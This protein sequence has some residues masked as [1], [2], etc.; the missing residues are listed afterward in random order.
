[1]SGLAVLAGGG[2]Y[3]VSKIP[4]VLKKNA[5]VVKRMEQ[6]RFEVVNTGEAVLWK[7]YALTILD[8]KGDE[9]AGFLEY[10]DKLHEIKNIEGALFDSEGKELKRL[11]NRQIMDITGNDDDNLIDDRRRKYHNFYFK[12]YP[13]T[14]QYEVEIRF[15]GTMFFPM[16][17]PRED[18]QYSVEQSSISIV[19]PA[20]YTI[21]FKSYN[22]NGDPVAT[23]GEKGKKVLTWQIKELPAIDDEFASPSWYEINTA[24]LFAPAEFEL[25]Q[26][27]GS[28]INWQEFGKFVYQLKQGR[29]QLPENIKQAVHQIADNAKDSREKIAA[30]YKY[31]QKNTR[32]ISIQL[33]I[34][35]WQPFD[36]KYVAAKSYGDCKA[37]TN[38]MYSLL[39]EAGISSCYT[40]VKAGRNADKI[41]AD[42]PS[43]QFNH[44][45]LCIPLQKDT[46]W[47]EC[48]S[49]TMPVGYLGDFTC[50]RYALMI[51]ENGGTLVRTPKYSMQENLELRHIKATLDK[52]ATLQVKAVTSY[53][54]LQQDMYHDLI[55]SLSKDK[56]KEFLHEQLDFATYEVSN[57]DYKEINGILP[58][59][60]ETLDIAV[61]NYATITGKRLFIIPNIM[62]RTRRK[63][64][65]NEERKFDIELDFE[66]T[67]VDT[68]EITLPEGYAL[69]FMPQDV[70]VNSKFGRY[71]CSVKLK[72]N[73]LLY[74][75]RMEYYGGYFP[76]K[77][78][79]EL[80]K[81]YETIYKADRNKVVLVKGQ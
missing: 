8:E 62:T 11:K 41:I 52:E 40:L 25:Q 4:D 74:Y 61:S 22:Y 28:M 44:V 54:G 26:Y 42:F 36:A 24:V 33:G 65:A 58:T 68:V 55:H 38:Y 3:A 9:Q 63:L 19:Y 27:K 35:G 15:N 71:Y 47:L 12:V 37:L 59:V 70:L 18:E 21:R 53:G 80:V 5:H 6:V 30:L 50:D 2:E 10:Y 56:V 49:Q 45:I 31:M 20:D 72:G 78:Y 48:T 1:S 51:N 39:K 16:W 43:Q 17:L 64:T 79:T 7:K 57:F 23:A 46:M 73:Q 29:D 81:F 76:A 60:Q 13:Y 32:Y 34:G 69:E 66:Y 67:D 14:V 77:D 75:R